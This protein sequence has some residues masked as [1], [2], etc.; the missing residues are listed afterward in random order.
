M[1]F[2]GIRLGARGLGRGIAVALASACAPFAARALIVTVTGTPAPPATVGLGAPYSMNV[3][4]LPTANCLIVGIELY[5]GPAA[6]GPW[7]FKGS[8]TGSQY[9]NAQCNHTWTV[10]NYAPGTWSWSGAAT[11]MPCT[12]GTG[13]ML[14]TG[15]YGPYITS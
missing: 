5:S 8:Y 7:T 3:Q 14:Q 10:A 4:A 9:C 1:A 11:E 6:T 13:F 2:R 15:G 12:G